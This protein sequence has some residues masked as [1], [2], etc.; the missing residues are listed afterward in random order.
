MECALVSKGMHDEHMAFQRESYAGDAELL[1]ALERGLA[2]AGYEKAQRRMADFLVIRPEKS[3]RVMGP[4]FGPMGIAPK[5]LF[6]GDFDRANDWLE[7]AYEVHSANLPYIS[8]QPIWDPLRSDPRFQNLLR[9]M[10]LPTI[11]TKSD[12]DEQR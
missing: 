12:P 4:G 9:R 11:S 2:E 7:T 8:F 6:A 3:G 1:T 5:Y 10:N